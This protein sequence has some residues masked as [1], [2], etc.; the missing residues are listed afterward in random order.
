MSRHRILI[1]LDPDQQ[2]SV[3]D[4]VVA[5]DAGVEQLFRHGWQKDLLNICL[6]EQIGIIGIPTGI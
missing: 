1:Q 3:F 6:Q 4:S 2:P 5:V